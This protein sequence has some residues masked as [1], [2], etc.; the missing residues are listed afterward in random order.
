VNS[1]S[2]ICAFL[3][4]GLPSL[5]LAQNLTYTNIQGSG[6]PRTPVNF[7]AK[8][9]VID[10]NQNLTIKKS[11]FIKKPALSKPRPWCGFVSGTQLSPARYMYASGHSVLANH[12]TFAPMG[13]QLCP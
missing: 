12:Y 3:V 10:R 8:F 6:S 7:T 11:S 9:G 13:G 1:K 2:I 4:V 5:G